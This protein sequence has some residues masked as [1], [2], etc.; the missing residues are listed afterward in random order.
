MAE[1]SP[2]G[3]RSGACRLCAHVPVPPSTLPA[4]LFRTVIQTHMSVRTIRIV[5]TGSSREKPAG[6][7]NCGA[8]GVRGNRWDRGTLGVR[9][10]RWGCSGDPCAS[11]GLGPS[12]PCPAL[13]FA[14]PP[15][16]EAK[17][18]PSR[19]GE[20]HAPSPPFQGRLPRQHRMGRSCHRCQHTADSAQVLGLPNSDPPKLP[21]QLTA[22]ETTLDGRLA[23]RGWGKSWGA[24]LPDPHRP[25][26]EPQWLT[27]ASGW[28]RRLHALNQ[29]NA[30]VLTRALFTSLRDPEPRP[31]SR[32]SHQHPTGRESLVLGKKEGG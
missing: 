3:G 24:G 6:A 4:D 15:W 13:P 18:T 11:P 26:P 17:G 16:G 31:G 10:E 8:D 7:G 25:F 32:A 21:G 29:A 2:E 22:A 14:A 23:H 28:A 12:P 30:P 9:P 20:T 5:G 27:G 1:Q 19:K